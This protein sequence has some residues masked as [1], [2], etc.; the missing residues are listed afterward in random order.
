MNK[1]IYVAGIVAAFLLAGAI[2]G[3]APAFADE[4][5]DEENGEEERDR[6][7]SSIG[8]EGENDGD[9]SEDE[10]DDERG[11]VGGLSGLVLYGV[12]AAV[13]GTIGYTGYKI[14]VSRKKAVRASS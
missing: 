1:S 3:I 7:G 10:D 6:E 8:L 12:I 13:V 14:F 11:A 4:D 9:E 5:D 2:T